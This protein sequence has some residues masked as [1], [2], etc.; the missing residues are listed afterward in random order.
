MNVT[1]IILE[2]FRNY[3]KQELNLAKELNI[4]IGNN[5]QGKTNVIESI[6]VASIGKSFRTN[7]DREMIKMEQENAK[8][9]IE[10]LKNDKENAIEIL[11]DKE[12]TKQVLLKLL[13]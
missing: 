12:K 6:Y 10:Y 3:E 11:F 1:K 2:N 5:A 8:I 7:M 9:H 4:F 13:K